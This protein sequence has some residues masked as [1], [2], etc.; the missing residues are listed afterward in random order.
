MWMHQEKKIKLSL[1]LLSIIIV[2]FGLVYVSINFNKNQMPNSLEPIKI[3]N[4]NLNAGIN[5]ESSST[6]LLSSS[7]FS[8]LSTQEE[9]SN[10]YF[11]VF[12]NSLSISERVHIIQQ[13]DPEVSI[14]YQYKFIPVLSVKLSKPLKFIE[15]DFEAFFPKIQKIFNNH[16][17][18][19][20]LSPL[21]K[22]SPLNIDQD[23]SATQTYEEEN[24]NWWLDAIDVRDL[25]YTGEN[26]KI[27][28][29]D[30]GISVHPDFFSDGNPK[31]S[32]IIQGMNFTGE[33]EVNSD[34]YLFDEYGHGTHCAGIAAGNGYISDGYYRGVAPEAL[35][36]NAK[37]S[38]STGYIDEDNVV[39]AIEWCIDQG[40]DIISMSFGD[41]IPEVWNVQT[42]AVQ[43][44]TQNGIVVFSSAGNS[45]P[46]FYSSGTPAS[47]LYSISVG[48]TDKN[49]Q[50]ASFSSWGPTYTNQIGPE[51]SAPGV[52]IIAPLSRSS[53]INEEYKI[54]NDI[55]STDPLFD[56]V[57]L[58][59][60]SMACPMAAG[61]AAI[62]LEAFPNSSPETIRNAL[63]L[64]AQPISSSIDLLNSIGTG[65]GLINVSRSLDILSSWA[66][67]DSD[68][69]SNAV[70][71]PHRF[72]YSPFDFL[73]YPGDSILLNYSLIMGEAINI[74]IELPEFTNILFNIE[75]TTL[76]SDS[77]GIID[78]PI[79]SKILFNASL[80][81]YC[82]DLIVKDS[83]SQ[84]ILDQIPINITVK[85][86]K[87][88]ILFDAYHGLN[89]KYPSNLASFSQIDL[90]FLMKTL[91]IENYQTIFTMEKWTPYYNFSNDGE[92]LNAQTLTDIDIL[93]L[94]TPII[95]YS[96]YEIESISNYYHSGG[97]IL[98]LGT[99]S[100]LMCTES[101]SQLF[102]ELGFDVEFGSNLGGIQ[103]Y[104]LTTRI[105]SLDPIQIN[106]SSPIFSNVE[107]ISYNYGSTFKNKPSLNTLASIGDK[108]IASELKPT[109]SSG[110]CIL[111]GDYH[112]FSTS[113]YIS[114]NN[115]EDS[116][117]L[118]KNLFDFLV[119]DQDVKSNIYFEDRSENQTAVPLQF[120]IYDGLDQSN[121]TN[122]VIGSTLNFSIVYPNHT[123][124]FPVVSLNDGQNAYITSISL[125]DL[126]FS[127]NPIEIFINFTYGEQFY[128][129]SYAY[130][131]EYV[132][133][134]SSHIIISENNYLNRT[135]DG[136]SKFWVAYDYF[137]P[138]E[139]F[140]GIIFPNSVFSKTD[141]TIL[142]S[143]LSEEENQTSTMFDFQNS[144]VSGQFIIV[145]NYTY[146]SSSERLML[147]QR[148][149][150]FR[151]SDI[152]PRIILGLS[153]INGLSFSDTVDGDY[154]VPIEVEVGGIYDINVK[155]TDVDDFINAG[156]DFTVTCT[157]FPILIYKNLMR[158]LYP[159]QYSQS[160]FTYDP[161]SSIFLSEITIPTSYRFYASNN[162]IEYPSDSNYLDYYTIAWVNVKDPNAGQAD[163][164]ILLIPFKDY[165][166]L[167]NWLPILILYSLL[168]V[169]II[170]L[171]RSSKKKTKVLDEFEENS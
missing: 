120:S 85:N 47:G 147:F 79:Y 113:N 162:V 5:L 34:T 48:A 35:L 50:L 112:I 151:I 17:T 7:I 125:D 130:I 42:L 71:L 54:K 2:Q 52:K 27:A 16:Q 134:I 63:L 168:G 115:Y 100:N 135:M 146:N 129:H 153:S 143:S 12:Q 60:T 127:L 136:A 57:P 75:S 166:K 83:T 13:I 8:E 97:S 123:S 152:N 70:L 40:V 155:V 31:N 142:N 87:G 74:E 10:R 56:Y 84:K 164:L 161:S 25:P 41:T 64:G 118:T 163:F 96:Q 45:G 65:E 77:S 11:V 72:P 145:P 144:L 30:T 110:K 101:I 102:E 106:Q 14:I 81:S 44:A 68:L 9:S 131:H 108:I 148:R 3:S 51:I 169:S 141:L 107:K 117:Q 95:P 139:A 78:V 99:F 22:E 90:Y 171:Q 114:N 20:D 91:Q 19:L 165:P 55:I 28:I 170:L 33:S 24:E 140:S 159:V 6:N 69:N 4:L 119:N 18:S 154:I 157:L 137:T 86:P 88:K 104:V 76:E 109:D 32:R 66:S 80:G 21:V 23:V 61:A 158:P 38:N 92:V 49:N 167:T 73:N 94:Q 82:G 122:F 121:I 59:G 37:I 46:S 53:Y 126:N 58:S 150:I 138:P 98:F 103:D 128:S 26:I 29:I 62:L 124:Q 133:R 43:L 105:K 132:N 67:E 149:E 1:F 39:A 93:V 111:F 15:K 116:S 89:D 36:Y 160:S 156:A